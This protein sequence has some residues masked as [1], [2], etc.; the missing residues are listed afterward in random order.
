MSDV[1]KV[2]S[3]NCSLSIPI[4]KWWDIKVSG[5]QT[6]KIE[7]EV[8]GFFSEHTQQSCR[9]CQQD[10]VD[11]ESSHQGEIV[12]FHGKEIPFA[13]LKTKTATS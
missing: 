9:T 6:R 4:Q 12:Q 5:W 11:A 10:A 13:L 7:E 3:L 2:S 1:E 8:V